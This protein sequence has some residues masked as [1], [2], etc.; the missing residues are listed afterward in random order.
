MFGNSVEDEYVNTISA[1]DAASRGRSQ[2]PVLSFFFLGF[3]GLLLWASLYEIEEVT[4]GVGRV[5]PSQQ[6]QVIQT[7][8]GGLIQSIMVKEGDL[9]EE[10]A[11][12]MQIDDTGFSSTLGEL[13]QR[14]NALLAEKIR[15]DAEA[16]GDDI[17]VFSEDLQKRASLAVN[18]QKAVFGSRRQ[19]LK[20]EIQV[21]EDR[22]RQRRAQLEE[23][24]ATREKL[25]AVI[26][27]L[28]REVKLTSDLFK[29]GVVPEIDLLR[30][31]SQLAESEG[32]LRVADASLPKLEASVEEASSEIQSTKSAY[33]LTAK[34]RLA[35]LQQELAVVQE[36]IR[37][38][39][40]RVTRTL[41]K[42]PLRGVVNKINNNTI[43]SVVQPAKDIIEIVP[44]DD[45]LLI[46]TNIRPQ[47]VAFIKPNERASV[48]LTAY[49]YLIYGS[50]DGRV[51][52]IGADTITDQQGEAFFQVV[53]RTDRN[54]LGD[55]DQQF[56]ITPGMV[57]NVNIKTGR[58][59]VLSYLLKPFN[60][61]R[62]EAFRER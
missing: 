18:A 11:V 7:L 28:S 38:A 10:G 6:V 60:R 15:L 16:N 12:L 57:A 13:Q 51:E 37:S 24:K 30:L 45:S 50:L 17:V 59:T 3:C 49:D 44:V 46:Q 36:T 34:E 21:L 55:E 14:E 25:K 48:R 23:L 43:G 56:P 58:K 41:L 52:R 26:V 4:V 39:S 53:I 5:I 22:M 62:S 40:D 35:S 2:W 1:A 42:S 8:E 29:R 19:Q 20:G 54:Y 33:I 31:Q 61:A 27:P 9:V 32:N 47:D